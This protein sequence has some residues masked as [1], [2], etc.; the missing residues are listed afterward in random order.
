M[1]GAARR[2]ARPEEGA[3]EAT[4]VAETLSGLM[5]TR[6]VLETY[7]R[8]IEGERLMGSLSGT[9]AASAGAMVRE[10]EGALSRARVAAAAVRREDPRLAAVLELR[11]IEAGSWSQVATCMG[12]SRRT[13][14]R[15]NR[16]LAELLEGREDLLVILRDC[17]RAR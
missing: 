17:C 3:A 12:T 14:L 2:A 5:E 11:Y 8:R 1:R 9:G 16:R 6:R 4:E 15:L 13:A 7:R 10:L